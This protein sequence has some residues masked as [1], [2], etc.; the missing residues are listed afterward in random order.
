MDISD[1]GCGISRDDLTRVFEPSFSL[2]GS[3]DR[4]GNY[5]PD[6]QGTGYGMTSARKYVQQH[7]GEIRVSS[8]LHKGTCVSITLPILKILHQSKNETELTNGTL[9]KNRS[10]LL[11]EDEAA[12]SDIQKQILEAEPCCHRVQTAANGE[13]AITLM[14][15]CQF[16]CVCIDYVLP[17][18]YNGL[19]LYRH[20][21]NSGNKVPVLFISGNL[22]FIESI[23]EL[24]ADDSK[25]AYLAKTL[26]E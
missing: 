1:N 12:I 25:V 11:I 2:K 13:A 7:G 16:D 14:E 22:E 15:N 21:R 19:D 4:E 10:V 8:E 17:G 3:K 5:N 18:S 26:S 23:Q 6:V 24:K 20:I 9:Y